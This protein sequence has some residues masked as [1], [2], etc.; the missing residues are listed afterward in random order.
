MAEGILVRDVCTCGR[1]YRVKNPTA[2][3]SF[4]CPDCGQKIEISQADILLAEP[5]DSIEP[6]P[7]LAPSSEPEEPLDVIPVNDVE[8][9]LAD[10][11]SREGDA[12]KV[13]Y[14]SADAQLRAALS[15]RA[16]LNST[17]DDDLDHFSPIQ[18]RERVKHSFLGDVFMSFALAGIPSNIPKLGASALAAG[19]IY[20]IGQFL[21]ESLGNTL[22]VNWVVIVLLLFPTLFVFVYVMQLYWHVLELT[23]GGEDE[24]DWS[25]PDWDFWS[26]FVVPTFMLGVVTLCCTLPGELFVHYSS[27]AS[28]MKEIWG[29]GINVACLFFWPVAIMSIAVGHSFFFLRPDWL[30]RCVVAVGPAYL[31]V[32]GLLAAT[33]TAWVLLTTVD[34]TFGIG[35]PAG[36]LLR[37]LTPLIGMAVNVYLGYVVFRTLG[38]IFRYH[39][40]KLPF[41]F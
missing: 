24:L 17:V 3:F 5:L 25:Q 13:G 32:W 33:I 26:D 1:K 7:E 31:I 8:L 6:T 35:G 11:G 27:L 38:L 30:I 36:V 37:I 15:P 29:M 28:P 9:R 39:R 19:L 2:G 40:E 16:L 21:R 14:D 23:A 22:F 12:G 4:N 18:A 20:V 41:G 34:F 10:H